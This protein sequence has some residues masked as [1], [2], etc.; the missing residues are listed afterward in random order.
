MNSVFSRLVREERGQSIVLFVITFT[1]LMGL[2]AL[3]VNAGY[4]FQNKQRLRSATDATA[5][6]AA[7]NNHDDFADVS[8][9]APIAAAQM[10]DRSWPGTAISGAGYSF[11]ADG[12]PY[13]LQGP[14]KAWLKINIRTEHPVGYLFQNLLTFLGIDLSPLTFRSSAQA[15]IGVPKGLKQVAPLAIRC[16]PCQTPWPGWAPGLAGSRTW[17]TPSDPTDATTP[18]PLDPPTGVKP[19]RLMYRPGDPTAFDATF[20]PLQAFPGA[21]VA[22]VGDA[23]ASCNPSVLSGCGLE[24]PDTPESLDWLPA[25]PPTTTPGPPPDDAAA[26]QVCQQLD[27]RGD[28]NQLAPVY[29]DVTESGGSGTL[30]VIGFAAVTFKTVDASGSEITGG[31]CDTTTA[32]LRIDVTFHKM[33]FDLAHT[34]PTNPHDFGEYDFGVRTIGLSSPGPIG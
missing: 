26:Q 32:P 6:Q 15:T 20:M 27:R 22:N 25:P 24:V 34:N 7:Q 11:D 4:W 9:N 14:G 18:A 2:L 1:A 33:F 30:H 19:V 10:A 5:L 31:G 13:P 29:D 12:T 8:A 3:V 23:L 17:P 28:W 16:S 21:T